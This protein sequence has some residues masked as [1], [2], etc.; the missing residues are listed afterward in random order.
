MNYQY[1]IEKEMDVQKKLDLLSSYPTEKNKKLYNLYAQSLD[2]IKKMIPESACTLDDEQY[3][4]HLDSEIFFDINNKIMMLEEYLEEEGLRLFQKLNNIDFNDL[5][6]EQW[7]AY[8]ILNHHAQLLSTDHMESSA[9]ISFDNKE[10][11]N[12]MP[13]KIRKGIK[14]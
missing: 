11:F 9:W 14:T 13:V 12:N 10:I 6:Q 1:W 7:H 2:F 5:S 4:T 3:Q 8:K